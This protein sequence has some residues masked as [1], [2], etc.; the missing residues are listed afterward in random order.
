MV[1]LTEEE[2]A[3]HD[4]EEDCW[5]V[6]RG[7]VYNVSSYLDDHPGGVEIVMDLAGQD[8]TEDYDDVGHSE[9]ADGMLVDYYVGDLN[10]DSKNKAST[11]PVKK[12][13]KIEVKKPVFENRDSEQTN[14]F[15]YIGA[16]LLIATASFYIFRKR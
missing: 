10:Q 3:K 2:V 15:L 13:T 4:T 8:A 12:T 11:Q 9:E 16:G 5:L 6:I 7:K 1:I 14:Y